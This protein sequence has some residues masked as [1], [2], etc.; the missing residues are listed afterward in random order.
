MFNSITNLPAGKTISLLFV[1]LF[2]AGLINSQAQDT[3]AQR[4]DFGGTSRG[5]AA[6]FSIGSKGYIGTGNSYGGLKKDFWE[7]DTATNAW[8]QKADFGGI[9]RRDAVGFSIGDKGYIGTGYS[10]MGPYLKDFWEYDPS[11]NTWTQKADFGGGGRY[12]AAGFSIGNKGYIGTG[13]N[14]YIYPYYKND[15]WEYNPATDI[16]TQK[17]NLGSTG[18]AY[19]IGFSINRK[20]YIGTGY[21]PTEGNKNDFWE[22][23]PATNSWTQK[24]DF[25]G[26]ARRGAVGFSIG[27]KGYIGTGYDNFFRKDFWEFD[28]VKNSWTQR[29][30][31]GGI[32]R[33]DA[34]GF[35]IGTK[36]Y[37]GTG[38]GYTNDFWE[39]TAGGVF[40]ATPYSGYTSNI[41]SSSATVAW[42]D[43][44]TTASGY[45]VLYKVKTTSVWTKA[46]ANRNSRSKTLT[47]LLPGTTYFWKVSANC[48]SGL[49]TP[50]SLPVTFTTNAGIGFNAITKTISFRIENVSIAVLPN[51]VTLSNATIYYTLLNNGNTSLNIIDIAGR[52]LQNVQ[53]GFQNAGLHNYSMNNLASNI[54]G[55]YM[56]V[57][58]QNGNTIARNRFVIGR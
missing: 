41:S 51:P 44:T 46:V 52:N 56:I 13:A 12:Y 58:Q 16:W 24:S 40:C 57:L 35:S 26:T 3:W 45:R 15:L 10:Y 14:F 34:V 9:E 17:A 8:T 4:A 48:G 2:T 28:A 22:Y 6:G 25:G 31:F 36:G 1:M 11:T 39:Y 43:S 32:A 21:N 7:Y 5:A 50:F 38:E 23:D 20:G 19:S 54:P 27:T 55:I 37:I 47:G 30:D 49:N 42:Y 18:R 53:L 29:T 33:W